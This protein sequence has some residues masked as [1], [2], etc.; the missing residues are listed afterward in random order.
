M[1]YEY[2]LHNRSL[3]E[4]LFPYMYAEVRVEENRPCLLAALKYLSHKKTLTSEEKTFADYNLHRIT[5]KNIY[6]GFFQDFAGKLDLPQR[7]LRERYVEYVA[8]PDSDVKIFYRTG[9]GEQRSAVRSRTMTDM[10]QGIRVSRFVLFGD[11]QLEYWI[12]ETTMDGRVTQSANQVIRG[13]SDYARLQQE[14]WY[15]MLDRMMEA[16]RQGDQETLL[17]L[18]KEYAQKR[19]TVQQMMRPL[20]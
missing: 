20:P 6:F 9:E 3:P 17:R 8:S 19:E 14:G 18:M 13:G 12:Q 15:N 7:I 10:F 4:E 5:A 1:S 11:E 16:R 2:L